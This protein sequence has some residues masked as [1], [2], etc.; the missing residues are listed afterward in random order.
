VLVA[1]EEPVLPAG[2]D[3]LPVLEESAEGCDAGARADHDERGVGRRRSEGRVGVDVHGQGC[4]RCDAVCQEGGTYAFSLAAVRGVADDV[5]GE[6][7][8]VRM[9]E[10]TGCDGVEPG[11]EGPEA[12]DEFAGCEGGARQQRQEI[13]DLAAGQKARECVRGIRSEQGPELRVLRAFGHGGQEGFRDAGDVQ[14]FQEGLAEGR[15][16]GM[17]GDADLLGAF[18]VEEL[19]EFL[20]EFGVVGGPDAEGITGFVS[21][22]GSGDGDDDVPDVFGGAVPCEFAVQYEPCGE[23]MA[24]RPGWG[25][26][27]AGGW[28]PG[29]GGAGG[30]VGGGSG[31]RGGGGGIRQGIEGPGQPGGEGF[32][33]VHVAILSGVDALRAELFQPGVQ[34]FA[35]LTELRVVPVAEGAE[36]ESDAFQAG[37]MIG[38]DFV[39]ECPGVVGRL[40]IAIGAGDD[41]EIALGRESGEVAGAQFPDGRGKTALACLFGDLFGQVFGV[42]GLGAEQDGERLQWFGCG[43]GS[44]V[45]QGD[46]GEEAGQEAVEPGPLL[47]GE[48]CAFGYD[49]NP[50]AGE[51]SGCRG[52]R[53]RFVG[54]RLGRQVC[55]RDRGGAFAGQRGKGEE[56]GIHT[57]MWFHEL[58]IS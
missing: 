49:G 10:R 43:A 35:E 37:G 5:D 46:V 48:G 41:E 25:A 54:G 28:G 40:A 56:I 36:A 42:A 15:G 9:A 21:E 57:R 7:D 33:E 29:G 4:V 58:N 23:G 14:M 30:M 8:L 51:G 17:S 27:G 13:H 44:G 47:R 20:D 45:G 16:V 12:G 39:P 3:G 19:E 31:L 1:E 50:T 38:A 18:G 22:A 26:A 34:V 24:T 53:W 32:F 2:G 11:L 6:M 55:S 52:V